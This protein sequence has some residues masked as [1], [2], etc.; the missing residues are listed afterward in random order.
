MTLWNDSKLVTED[1]PCVSHAETV[2][3][4]QMLSKSA[5][6]IL[7]SLDLLAYLDFTVH[8]GDCFLSVCFGIV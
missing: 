5:V 8:S 7:Q 3:I 4:V 1:P 6:S 2:I